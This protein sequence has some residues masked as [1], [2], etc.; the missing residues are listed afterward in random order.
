[1]EVVGTECHPYDLSV[2][3]LCLQLRRH[4][5]TSW[6][7]GTALRTPEVRSQ[8]RKILLRW[9]S[10]GYEFESAG[11]S[12]RRRRRTVGLSP[13]SIKNGTLRGGKW[14]KRWRPG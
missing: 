5:R 6:P 13:T 2:S 3:P 10:K 8:T 4:P 1:M 7:S 14:C 11:G 9:P 12:C